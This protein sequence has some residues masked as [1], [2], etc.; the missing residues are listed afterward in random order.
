[1]CLRVCE[2]GDEVPLE[3]QIVHLLAKCLDPA[4]QFANNKAFVPRKQVA[5]FM[6][7][8]QKA[9]IDILIPCESVAER[10]IEKQ[11]FT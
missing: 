1:V 7:S 9:P 2:K 10:D 4:L 3:L 6:S 11:L 5:R 8:S